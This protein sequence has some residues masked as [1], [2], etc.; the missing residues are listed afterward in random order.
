MGEVKKNKK[1]KKERSKA[2]IW[3]ENI[4]EI[5]I[6]VVCIT[7]SIIT[8]SNP[9][10]MKDDYSKISVNSLPV[11]SNSM[12]G[13]DGFEKGDLILGEKIKRDEKGKIEILDVG[14]VAIFVVND[15]SI[16]KYQFLN[17]HRVVG[18]YY[19]YSFN[20]NGTNRYAEGYGD[21]LGHVNNA[22][23]ANEFAISKEWTD[24]KITGYVTSGDNKSIYYKDGNLNGELLD[25]KN[26]DLID[27]YFPSLSG[28]I[29]K[30]TGR[31]IGGLGG[32][33]TWVK[34][35]THFFFVVLLPLGIL[36]LLN[37][38]TIIKYVIDIKTEKAKKLALEEA[39]ASG[40]AP[41]I[42]EEEIKRRAVEEYL[43]QQAEKEQEDE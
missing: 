2:S 33:I 21:M 30:W 17:T 32:V 31:K 24:F 28:V 8:I 41:V 18:Y 42:D 12:S 23:E 25:P 39:Q 40:A 35:P 27:N 20:D 34:E 4:I 19:T 15:P 14:D 3:I 7:F 16:S 13:K 36:F 5:I 22:V 10:G 9:G 29:G 38:W 1:I 26:T 11:L 43:K 6:M 37:I